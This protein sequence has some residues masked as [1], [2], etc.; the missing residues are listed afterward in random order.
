MTPDTNARMHTGHLKRS[1]TTLRR[2]DVVF[3]KKKPPA[4]L[5]EAQIAAK[6]EAKAGAN[7]LL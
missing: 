1:K 6:K 3:T 5:S 2:S 4:P 7:I